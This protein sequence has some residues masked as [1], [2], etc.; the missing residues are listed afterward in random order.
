LALAGLAVSAAGLLGA[1]PG[2]SAGALRKAPV[3]RPDLKPPLVRILKRSPGLGSG[4]IMLTPRA[5]AR[6]Q[7]TGPLVI[8]N[9]G[10]ARF[11]HIAGKG[12]SSVGL[13]VQSYQGQ[14]VLT[15]SERPPITSAAGIYGG[16]K[17]KMFNV[18]MDQRYKVLKKVQAQGKGV[19]TDLHDFVLTS[20]GTA[21]LLGYRF[22]TR[23]LRKFGFSQHAK[24]IDCQVQEID[25]KTG[26]MIFNWNAVDH[27]PLS[28]AVVKPTKGQAWDYF[29]ANSVSVDSDGNLLVSARHTSTVYKIGRW[30]K[31]KHQVLWRLGGKRSS[32]KMGPGTKFWYQH[33]AVLRPDGTL[34]IFDN[35]S[36]DF[37]RSHGKTSKVLLLKL[38]RTKRTASVARSIAHPRGVL[39]VSQGNAE[40]LSNGNTFVGWGSSPTLA[41]FGPDGTLLFDAQV[42][43]G[44]YQSYRAFRDDWHGYPITAPKAAATASGSALTVYASWNGSTETARWRVLAG[45][46]SSSLKP[47]TDRPWNGIET[48]IKA[49]SA[50]PVVA[51]EALDGSGKVIGKSAAVAVKR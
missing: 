48:R 24:V 40:L 12:Q 14:P 27:V 44:R 43:T 49:T 29:H 11:Y 8:D 46:S 34:S 19:F 7:R 21:L 36:A 37:D 26:K 45:N 15:W 20:R 33:D 17:R 41:E 6:T 16:D 18:I 32:Y 4:L 22:V 2:A 38:D 50:A 1:A 30:G 39:S 47:V 28:D 10:R 51:V 42:P 25:L 23:D 31:R 3:T 9:F 35:N 5:A 13:H